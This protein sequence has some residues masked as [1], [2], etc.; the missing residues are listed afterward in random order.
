MPGRPAAAGRTVYT[1]V[2]LPAQDLAVAW[3]A[4]QQGRRTGRGRDYDFLG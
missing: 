2:G 4:Y 1:P 3:T